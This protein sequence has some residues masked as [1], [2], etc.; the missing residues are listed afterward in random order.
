[1]GQTQH[2]TDPALAR[3][4]SYWGLSGNILGISILE[5]GHNPHVTQH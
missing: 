5:I 3:A 1:M 2:G 4:Q